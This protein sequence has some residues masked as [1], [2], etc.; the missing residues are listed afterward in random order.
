MVLIHYVQF[1][2]VPI[3]GSQESGM[4]GKARELSLRSGKTWKIWKNQGIKFEVKENLENL[5]KSGN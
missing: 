1:I 5:E 4:T 3:H 2:A